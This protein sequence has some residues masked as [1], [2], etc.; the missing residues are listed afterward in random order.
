MRT[1]SP[2]HAAS[3]RISERVRMSE[4]VTMNA[5]VSE[6]KTITYLRRPSPE[7][8]ASERISERVR[9]SE[10]DSECERE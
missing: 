1:Q 3:E 2:E 6:R 8:T 10:S 4:G 5:S 7:Y 9:V